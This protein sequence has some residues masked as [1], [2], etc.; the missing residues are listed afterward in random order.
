[1]RQ[2]SAQLLDHDALVELESGHRLQLVQG[3]R[4]IAEIVP[5]S[6]ANEVDAKEQKRLEAVERLMEIMERGI[7]LGGL[8]I[9]DRDE[10]Y[11][12]D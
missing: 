7:N 4:T 11:E 5:V 12:R 6:G 10:L 3:G 8:K 2:I 1:M 9:T